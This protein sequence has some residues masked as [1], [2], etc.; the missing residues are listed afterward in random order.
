MKYLVVLMG[1]LLMSA[2]TA[3]TTCRQV[4]DSES[5]TYVRVCT[6]RDKEVEC[7]REW[8]SMAQEHVTVC[9]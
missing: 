9:E 4:W 8:D 7:R 3:D 2:A 6:E 1:V 5:G